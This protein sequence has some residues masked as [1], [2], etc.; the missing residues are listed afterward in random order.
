M[1]NPAKPPIIDT[2]PHDLAH[3]PEVPYHR[4]SVFHEDGAYAYARG[5]EVNP[6]HLPTA[7]EAMRR[8]GWHLV[9]LFGATDSKHVGFVFKRQDPPASDPEWDASKV[10]V[11]TLA[12]ANAHAD[13]LRLERR[14][15]EL[16]RANNELVEQNR[17]LKRGPARQ[18]YSE[19]EPG[20]P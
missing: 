19:L 17:A 4:F 16:L 18:S 9:S 13:V 6:T 3:G 5:L 2:A 15:D 12:L 1:T 20:N 7:L 10:D 11:L 14:V 8:S